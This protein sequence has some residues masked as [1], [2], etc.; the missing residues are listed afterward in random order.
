MNGI[1]RETE[2]DQTGYF[3]VLNLLG[4]RLNQPGPPITQ[5]NPTFT[6]VQLRYTFIGRNS[7]APIVLDRTFMSFYDFDTGVPRFDGS[8]T[9]V[10]IVQIGPE[11]Q[12]LWLAAN[13][14]IQ[15]R[16]SWQSFLGAAEYATFASNNLQSWSNP[17]FTATTCTQAAFQ[18]QDRFTCH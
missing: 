7:G 16:P 12:A 10:E 13:T 4:P 6:F 18:T 17:L 3:G 14:E 8:D 1:K 15:Q 9:Q 5:W 11:T 2:G